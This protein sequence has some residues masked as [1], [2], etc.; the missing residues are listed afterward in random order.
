[1][2]EMCED[3][4]TSLSR[5]PDAQRRHPL[6]SGNGLVALLDAWMAEDWDDEWETS[7]KVVQ[8]LVA[9]KKAAEEAMFG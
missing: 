4:S 1:M 3:N 6:K 5:H 9:R 8:A 7:W 2:F